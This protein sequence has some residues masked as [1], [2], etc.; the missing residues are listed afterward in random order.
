MGKF[1][2][3]IIFWLMVFLWL[4]TP[5]YAG[6]LATRVEGVIDPVIA[7]HLKEI[8]QKAER[9]E[10]SFVL[11]EL[12]TPG[13]LDT[14]MREITSAIL[15]AKVPV[16]VW[17]GPSGARAASAGTFILYSAQVAA[18]APQT[19]IGS[20][21]P[22][23]LGGQSLDQDLRAK[24]ENDAVSY[25]TSLAKRNGRN[26][27]WAEEAVRK[28]VSVDAE[29]AYKK[30]IINFIAKNPEEFLEKAH[31]LR[32][33]VSGSELVLNLKGQRIKYLDLSLWE[34]FLHAL[35]NPELAYFLIL[36]GIYGL[37]YEFAHPGGM[38][39]GITGV[40]AL[41]MAFYSLSV[42]PT[43]LTGLLLLLFGLALIIAE[44]YL[45]TFG[46]LGVGGVISITLGSLFLFGT[47]LPGLTISWVN[48]LPLVLLLA[49]GVYLL[50][51]LAVRAQKSKS[52]TGME[53]M[54]GLTGKVTADLQPEGFVMVR[55]EIWKAKA[56][57][58]KTI[59]RGTPVKVIGVNGLT[60]VVDEVNES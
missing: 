5:V 20:A 1:R 51:K 37:I 39:G 48:I 45:P 16:G 54:I 14:S 24:V 10:A 26:P 15:A 33:K 31:G 52:L 6:V 44:L 38:V 59:P 27:V 58:G 32:V 23:N 19:T 22:V 2:G 8:I 47:D 4:T 42:L 41:L 40:L 28:S 7:G 12:N 21:H 46:A 35:A 55:G 60:L 17:V 30:G 49:L 57:E 34:K 9:E 56:V 13:G 50:I 25:I 43:T 36:V 53:G 11:I 29:E 18:M 3:K